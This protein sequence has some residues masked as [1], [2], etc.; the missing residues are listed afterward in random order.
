MKRFI[1]GVLT[2]FLVTFGAMVGTATAGTGTIAK[3]TIPF[4]FSVGDRTY[5]AGRYSLTELRQHV[6]ALYDDRGRNVAM[7]LA[8]DVQPTTEVS[9]V[10][11]LKFEVVDGRRVLAEVW[12]EGDSTGLALPLKEVAR[13]KQQVSSANVSHDE[14]HDK[15]AQA[16]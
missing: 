13:S 8:Y 7:V 3:V 4:E 1:A 16:N 9:A 12:T 6:I 5:P 14:S 2:L 11:Q 10:S 15:T